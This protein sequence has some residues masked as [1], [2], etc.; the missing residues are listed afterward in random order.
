MAPSLR[1]DFYRI[2][3]S[4][5]WTTYL[6]VALILAFFWKFV[7]LE[8]KKQFLMPPG[9]KGVPLLGNLLQLIGSKPIR[10]KMSEWKQEFGTYCPHIAAMSVWH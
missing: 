5:S 7:V 1:S 8:Y 10:D 6:W 4:Y 3:Q 2:V 9:P